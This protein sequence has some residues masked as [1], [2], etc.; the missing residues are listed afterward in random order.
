[1]ERRA[2]IIGI[3][4]ASGSGKTLVAQ[5]ILRSH[6]SEHIVII[7]EDS[8][9]KDLSDIPLDLRHKRNFDHPDAFDHALLKRH[10]EAMLAGE[11]VDVPIYD[12][13]IHA[14]SSEYRHL[15][16]RH[17]I[18]VEGILLLN[19][20]SVR[21]M[22]D[23]KIFVDTPADICLLRRVRRDITERGRSID[24]VL[25]QYEATVRPMFLQF[26][27]PSKRYADIILPM[28]GKN[29]VAIDLITTKINQLLHDHFVG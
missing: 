3:A 23:I 18:I 29:M 17:I 16:S 2:I 4:G 26:I 8:Y 28:G 1:M 11:E 22:M 6:P 9:Y 27:E 19:D 5:N 24:S 10:L 21:D 7:E 15:T 13:S 14:R 25:E 12:Y 20:P